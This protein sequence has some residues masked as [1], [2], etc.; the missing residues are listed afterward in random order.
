MKETTRCHLCTS[1]NFLRPG[2]KENLF[3]ISQVKHPLVIAWRNLSR[4]FILIETEGL[5]LS[6]IFP[7]PFSTTQDGSLFFL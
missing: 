5:S 3:F 7:T 1:C 6:E 4:A 2:E